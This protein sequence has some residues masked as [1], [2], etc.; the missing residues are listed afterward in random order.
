VPPDDQSATRTASVADY[1]DALYSAEARYWWRSGD[2]YAIEPGAH[3]TS[4]L[5]QLSLRLIRERDPGP[6]AD[7][8]P[9][10]LDLGAG[11]GADSIRL[12]LLGYDVTAV[13]ISLEAVKKIE[14]FAAEAGVDIITETA[15]ISEYQPQGQFDVVICNGVLH[16]V[17]DKTKAIKRMQAATAPGGLNVVSLWSTFTPVPK[18]HNSVPVYCDDEDGVVAT[19]YSRWN[20]KL[21]YFERGKPESSHEGMPAHAHSHIKILAEKPAGQLPG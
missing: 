5:T 19:S 10:A 20:L 15:D 16:Y 3:P 1:F 7:Q 21:L 8:R 9:R 18:C 13:E 2:P 14:C 17:A 6:A 4:L 12:A 11:E